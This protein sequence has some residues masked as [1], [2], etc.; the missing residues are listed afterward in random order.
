V[1]AAGTAAVAE[2]TPLRRGRHGLPPEQVRESQR[3]RLMAAAAESLLASGYAR[4]TVTEVAKLARVST[5]AFYKSFGDIWDC[6]ASAYE[7]NAGLLCERVEAACR[8]GDGGRDER[9][10]AAIEA[11]L[12]LLA[13]E[14]ALAHLL[15]A[16]PP[17]QSAELREARGRLVLRLSGLLGAARQGGVP[18]HHA[19]LIAAALGLVASRLRAEGA[20]GLGNLAPT[21]TGILLSP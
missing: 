8:E 16:A 10:G 2:M 13:A 5:A 4:L 1:S 21:L 17:A 15:C 11:A 3:R 19:R 20:E 7:A 6:L 9:S 12:E 14:P 18:T